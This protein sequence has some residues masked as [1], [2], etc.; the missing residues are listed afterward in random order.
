[1]VLLLRPGY[2]LAAYFAVLVWYPDYLRVSI[3]TL[4]ISAG[5]IVIT[6]LLLRCLFN[7]RLRS[8]FV[9]SPLDTWVALSMV[10]YVVMF[11]LTRPGMES[12]ENRGGFLMDTWLVYLAARLCITDRKAALSTVKLVAVVLVPLAVFGVVEAT[13]GWQLFMGLRQY[14]PW[15]TEF[16]TY[17]ARWGLTRAW[18]PSSHPIMFG[19]CFVMFLPL[20][21]ALRRQRGNW[22]SLAK[23]LSAI[24]IIG[25]LSSMSS[26][27][28]G[29]LM[30]VILCMALERYSH[31]LKTILALFVIMF[32]L[33]GI[34]SNRP[35]YHVLL[36]F[37]NLGK[38][39]WYQ[40]AKLI[41]VGIER[42]DEWWLAGYGGKDPGWGPAT[43]M[44]FTDCNNEFLLKGVQYGM[45]GVI[46]LAG[47]LAMAFRGLVRAF[48]ETP[49]K[50]LRSLYWAMGCALVGVVVI[51]QGV[52]FFGQPVA[53][54]YC[55]LGMIGS[56]FA[57]TRQTA[58]P[59]ERIRSVGN[60][61][62]MPM[63]GKA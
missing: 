18:G 24:A 49:D 62:F 47:T 53:L 50:E 14:C 61:D 32:V 48:K 40:R 36:E 44:S 34:V 7:D 43:G 60:S 38:G 11:C 33:L 4:D 16:P 29:M 9:W 54:F 41:D 42:I 56:S 23:W 15:R 37:G 63:Y 31:R 13:T 28:W 20:I 3:G 57:L 30:V 59:A 19:S 5:R 45:L 52:S 21:W 26:G 27:P 2:A 55:L 6:I 25:A 35:F 1:M 46:A 12:V 17:D 10:V 39:A 8:K 22:A 58:A 51:W